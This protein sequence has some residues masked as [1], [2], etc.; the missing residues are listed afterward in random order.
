MA[1]QTVSPSVLIFSALVLSAS[2]L[3]GIY[4]LHLRAQVFIKGEHVLGLSSSSSHSVKDDQ[5][6]LYSVELKADGRRK[7]PEFVQELNSLAFGNDSDDTASHPSSGADQAGKPMK[8]QGPIS[9][10]S[11][12]I[13]APPAPNYLRLLTKNLRV[14][15]IMANGA[16]IDGHFVGVRTRLWFVR[17]PEADK[18]T[19]HPILKYVTS[20]SVVL[21]DGHHDVRLSPSEN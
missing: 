8:I 20:K 7:H 21:T 17:L 2:A 4:E 6:Q 10:V 12:P 1:K 11:G 14:N 16:V 5:T 18:G 15:A 3:V 19:T 9:T 13:P